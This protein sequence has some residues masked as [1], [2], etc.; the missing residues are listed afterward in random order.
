[1]S[2]IQMKMKKAFKVSNRI[3]CCKISYMMYTVIVLIVLTP[4]IVF[5]DVDIGI[6]RCGDPLCRG[7]H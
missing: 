2:E 3:K 4:S 7:K 5:G 1:M 6:Q